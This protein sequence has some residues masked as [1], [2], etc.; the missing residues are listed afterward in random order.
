MLGSCRLGDDEAERWPSLS[1]AGIT[2]GLQWYRFVKKCIWETTILNSICKYC[3]TSLTLSAFR[4]A[5]FG[6]FRPYISWLKSNSSL[7]PSACQS[8]RSSSDKSFF[9]FLVDLVPLC[10]RGNLFFAPVFLEALG[11]AFNLVCVMLRGFA[12]ERFVTW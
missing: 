9:F 3:R 2:C 1:A 6:D 5:E 10:L 11:R 8:G 7:K 12:F 4:S